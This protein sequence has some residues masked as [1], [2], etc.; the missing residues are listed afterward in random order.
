MKDNLEGD[1]E[2]EDSLTIIPGRELAST[3]LV[4]I[5]EDEE[6]SIL[7][8]EVRP[9]SRRSN[10]NTLNTEINI[11]TTN[12]D[13][14]LEVTEGSKNTR[15]S[16]AQPNTRNSNINRESTNNHSNTSTNIRRSSAYFI[17]ISQKYS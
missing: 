9:N 10:L 2:R 3:E 12:K 5:K 7:I 13:E 14:K 6:H 11:I 8:Q 4:E 17:S 16:D 15:N 1:L